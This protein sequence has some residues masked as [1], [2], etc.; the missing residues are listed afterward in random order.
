MHSRIIFENSHE[1]LVVKGQEV[2]VAYLTFVLGTHERFQ[3]G[4]PAIMLRFEQG[5]FR[6]VSLQV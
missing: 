5:T 3:L 4:Y 1:S 6:G 2:V